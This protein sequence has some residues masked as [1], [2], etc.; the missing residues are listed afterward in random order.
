MAGL[1]F[2]PSSFHDMTRL[3]QV[4]ITG[5]ISSLQQITT[6][7][8]PKL[9]LLPPGLLFSLSFLLSLG[10]YETWG[11]ALGGR[12]AWGKAGKRRV[13]RLV[14]RENGRRKGERERERWNSPRF[15]G[16]F[17]SPNINASKKRTKGE[18]KRKAPHRRACV[19]ETTTRRREGRSRR[20][21]KVNYRCRSRY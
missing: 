15:D 3:K 11:R 9:S 21:R 10:H 17:F 8:D 14:K 18:K 12:K 7:Q 6:T 5:E 1:G 2:F 20:R 4:S 13:L 19:C 16:L